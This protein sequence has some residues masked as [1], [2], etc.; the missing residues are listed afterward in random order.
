MDYR[1]ADRLVD[2]YIKMLGEWKEDADRS[3]E[4]WK[5]RIDE[6]HGYYQGK[7]TAYEQALGC[8]NSIKE[9]REAA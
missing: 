7:A 1:L 4:E 6:L 9:A 8:M 5:G 3:A 2:G